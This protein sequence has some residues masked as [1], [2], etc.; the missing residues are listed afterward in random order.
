HKERADFFALESC[1]L[2]LPLFNL[3]HK[4]SW[5]GTTT[6]L[7]AALARYAPAAERRRPGWPRGVAAFAGLLR[8]LAPN[9]RT[10]GVG[11]E[12]VRTNGARLIEVKR[13]PLDPVSD[14]AAPPD[15]QATA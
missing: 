11:I 6:E 13:V 10:F 8:R 4:R 9:L 14:R 3:I 5:R 7:M 1:P 15:T 2:A 12:F